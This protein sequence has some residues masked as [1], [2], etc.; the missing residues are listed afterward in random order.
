MKKIS[1]TEIFFLF[2]FVLNT[3]ISCTLHFSN[4]GKSWINQ[5]TMISLYLFPRLHQKIVDQI[6]LGI[7]E[8]QGN[9]IIMV[10][11]ISLANQPIGWKH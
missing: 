1:K 9:T 2:I 5:K 11:G 4:R 8:I 10:C 6:Q 3:T 7:L